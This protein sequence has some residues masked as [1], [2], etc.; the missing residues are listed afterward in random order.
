M[1]LNLKHFVQEAT[2]QNDG[3]LEAFLS[4]SADEGLCQPP[5]SILPESRHLHHMLQSPSIPSLEP[6]LKERCVNICWAISKGF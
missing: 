6:V 3:L 4:I 5:L 1:H 2:K